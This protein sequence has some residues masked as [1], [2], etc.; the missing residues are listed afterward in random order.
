[1]LDDD[2]CNG[3][4]AMI[5]IN[6]KDLA[7]RKRLKEMYLLCTSVV[8]DIINKIR[9]QALQYNNFFEKLMDVADKIQT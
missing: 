1:M 5:N 9:Y 4:I 6:C 7:G 2:S 3:K 8:R